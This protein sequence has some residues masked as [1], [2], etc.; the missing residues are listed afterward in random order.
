LYLIGESEEQETKK[1]PKINEQ[2]KA[3]TDAYK[4]VIITHEVNFACERCIDGALLGI[5]CLDCAK[6]KLIVRAINSKSLKWNE[7]RPSPKVFEVSTNIDLCESF[8]K[9]D[10]CMEKRRCPF[11]HSLDEK[12]MWIR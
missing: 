9:Q 2:A 7:I 10:E 8:L 4:N 1:K 3:S 12:D 5:P 6:N 11:P